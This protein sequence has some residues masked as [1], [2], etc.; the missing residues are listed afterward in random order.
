MDSKHTLWCLSVLKKF[1]PVTSHVCFSQLRTK[2]KTQVTCMALKH[3]CN[4]N[5]SL[6]SLLF[7]LW[8]IFAGDL[9]IVLAGSPFPSVHFITLNSLNL[10]IL[11]FLTLLFTFPLVKTRICVKVSLNSTFIPFPILYIYIYMHK[12]FLW[13]ENSRF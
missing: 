3:V 13:P 5:I 1:I 10:S 11:I 4:I 7:A 6:C 9:S 12:I 2:V 8:M